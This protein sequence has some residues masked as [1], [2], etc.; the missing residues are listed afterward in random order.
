LRRIPFNQLRVEDLKEIHPLFED[1][2][3]KLWSYETR[4]ELPPLYSLS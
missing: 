2:V 1:D 4:Y 3:E